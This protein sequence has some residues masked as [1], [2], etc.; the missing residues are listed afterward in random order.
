MSLSDIIHF[1]HWGRND[2]KPRTPILAQLYIAATSIG[3]LLF[4]TS[5]AV[6][7][8][9]PSLAYHVFWPNPAPANKDEYAWFSIEHPYLG[10]GAKR[11]TKRIGCE[12]GDYLLYQAPV[13][14]CN[15][16]VVDQ[17]M[18]ARSNGDPIEAFAY[19]GIVPQGMVYM[20]GDRP[21][22]LD[23]RYFGL[24]PRSSLHHVTPIW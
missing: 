23:S 17:V 14:Y 15:G 21:T 2:P 20:L 22:S 5:H 9:T 1:L 3:A 4:F 24:V 13:H 6:I 10:K 16:T 18:P 11:L 7:T 12:A 8:V 19:D